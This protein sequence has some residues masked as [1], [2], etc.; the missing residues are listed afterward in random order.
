[1]T[2]GLGWSQE[3]LAGKAGLFYTYIGKVERSKAT[4]SITN[5]AK[6]AKVLKVEAN[7]LLIKDAYK[8]SS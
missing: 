5:L 6:I 2:Y 7:V 4:I 1:M 3:K 8:K